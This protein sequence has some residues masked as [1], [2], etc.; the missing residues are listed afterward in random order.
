MRVWCGNGKYTT[1]EMGKHAK[2]V[3][4]PLKGGN[5]QNGRHSSALLNT[6]ETWEEGRK[7]EEKRKNK[8]YRAEAVLKKT[9][10]RQCTASR[11]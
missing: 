2:T 1:T 10:A 11:A 6:I 8:K 3:D 7:R 4:F 9:D 5:T